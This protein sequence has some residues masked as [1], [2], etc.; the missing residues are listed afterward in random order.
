MRIPD[1]QKLKYKLSTKVAASKR[2]VDK[3]ILDT[4]ASEGDKPES[5]EADMVLVAIC[6]VPYTERKELESVGVKMISRRRVEIDEQFRTN[7]PNIYALL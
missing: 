2:N 6:R 3:V 1:K 5:L 4:E 7:V